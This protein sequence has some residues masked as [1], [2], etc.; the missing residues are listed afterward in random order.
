MKT[1][2]V[3]RAHLLRLTFIGTAIGLLPHAIK[4]DDEAFPIAFLLL[5]G[6][7]IYEAVYQTATILRDEGQIDGQAT[8]F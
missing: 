1:Q 6:T 5:F 4:F 3:L 2:I 8:S 7:L